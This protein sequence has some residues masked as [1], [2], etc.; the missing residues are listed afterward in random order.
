ML[1]PKRFGK[2]GV[3]TSWVVEYQNIMNSVLEMLSFRYVW[4]IKVE[5]SRRQIDMQAGAQEEVKATGAKCN[6][7]D[8]SR[9]SCTD[10]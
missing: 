6:I 1:V 10:I 9:K 4:V 5:I 3:R 8:L 7:I 2:A